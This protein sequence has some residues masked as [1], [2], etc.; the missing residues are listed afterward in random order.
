MSNVIAHIIESKTAAEV[1]SHGE[2]FTLISDLGGG[3]FAATK[4]GAILPATLFVIYA[5]GTID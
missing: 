1:W 5:G 2:K 4:T 3:L